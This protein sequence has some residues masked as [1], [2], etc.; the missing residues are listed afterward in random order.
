MKIQ[1]LFEH[2]LSTTEQEFLRRFTADNETITITRTADNSNIRGGT[3]QTGKRDFAT[4]KKLADK[5]LVRIVAKDADS[6]ATR[7][8]VQLVGAVNTELSD[9]ERDM[10]NKIAAFNSTGQ[11]ADPRDKSSFMRTNKKQQDA[12]ARLAKLG[13]IQFSTL[14]PKILKNL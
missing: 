14:S 4:A 13:Y 6:A 8:Q 3:A 11:Y 10:Y 2:T 9:L 1:D 5:G 12:M 7:L